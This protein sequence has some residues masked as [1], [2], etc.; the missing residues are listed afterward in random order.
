MP[1]ELQKQIVN[2][3]KIHMPDIQRKKA[4]LHTHTYE[5]MI[6]NLS[7]QPKVSPMSGFIHDPNGNWINT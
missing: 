2:K 7:D 1:E 3:L 6:E 5:I 4:V